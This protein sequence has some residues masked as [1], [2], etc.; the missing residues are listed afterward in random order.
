M[1]TINPSLALASLVGFLTAA[2]CTLITDVDRT[3]IP[4][5]AGAEGG[6]PGTGG[7]GATGGTSATGGTGGTGATGG[8]GEAGQ[9]N[10]GAGGTMSSGGSSGTGG[11]A[12]MAP[13]T[14]VCTRATG[15]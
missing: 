6:S 13:V 14:E 15:T 1:R 5:D 7:T 8:T 3:K 11:G 2:S 4:T 10:A 12:G 9:T